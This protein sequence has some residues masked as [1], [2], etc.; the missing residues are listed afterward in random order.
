MSQLISITGRHYRLTN[1]V[2]V[3]RPAR[4]PIGHRKHT[5]PHPSQSPTVYGHIAPMGMWIPDCGLE[6]RII[7]ADTVSEQPVQRVA[8]SGGRKRVKRADRNGQRRNATKALAKRRADAVNLLIDALNRS[9]KSQAEAAARAEQSGDILS[10]LTNPN[11]EA[12]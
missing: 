7:L 9:I 4:N 8:N 10:L 3:L 5:G 12:C 2:N 6:R 11:M 1:E